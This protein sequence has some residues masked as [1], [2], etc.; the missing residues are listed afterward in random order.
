[1]EKILRL[2][3]PSN[4]AV[5]QKIHVSTSGARDRLVWLGTK[6]GGFTVR[7]AYHL[8]KELT[9]GQK[10]QSSSGSLDFKNWTC[11]W[12]LK[13]PNAV[14]VFLWRAC[15][16]SLPT[17][18]NLFKKK[19]V[20]SPLCPVCCNS[21]ETAGHILWNCPSAMD[22]WSYGPKRIQKSSVRAE[23]FFKIIE[24]LRDLCD[25]QTLGAFVMIA[26]DIWQ[27]RNKL[28]FEGSFLHPRLLAQRAAHQ[29]EDFKLAQVVPMPDSRLHTNQASIWSPPPEGTVKVNWDVA[30][31]EARDRVGIGLIA[32]DHRGNVIAVKR[33]ARE[34]CVAPL[35][36]EAMGGLHVAMFASELNLS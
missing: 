17:M 9:T 21:D 22:V 34:G 32:R 27:R 23:S 14:K 31:S 1:M 26:R 7:S 4:A 15:L 18:S 3:G 28:V 33:V 20:S 24:E 35:L 19:I 29:L 2:L 13:I 11:F 36:A 10:G 5:I 25:I 8:Q 30:V 16:E 12:K 6:D